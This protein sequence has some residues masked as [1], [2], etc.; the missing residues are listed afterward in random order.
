MLND[1]NYSRRKGLYDINNKFIK[2]I[3]REKYFIA[4]MNLKK[5]VSKRYVAAV[6]GIINQPT[7][8]RVVPSTQYRMAKP[9]DYYFDVNQL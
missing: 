6:S 7:H 4:N 9:N 1:L 3:Q 5:L 2:K 8:L